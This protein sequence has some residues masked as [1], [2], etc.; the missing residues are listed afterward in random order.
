[1][2]SI[3]N[4]MFKKRLTKKLTKR[5][6]RPYIV[7]KVVSKNV[8]KLKLPAFIRI[9]LVMNISRVIRCIKLVKRQKVEKPKPIKVDGVEE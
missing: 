1:M 9:Y 8:M 2:L 3:K 6:M 4:L 5:Y 7:K